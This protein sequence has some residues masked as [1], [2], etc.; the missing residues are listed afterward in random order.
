MTREDVEQYRSRFEA[1]NDWE[2]RQPPIECS[3]E[4]VIA[5][6]GFLL[7]F[8][9]AEERL[10]DPDPEKLGVQRMRAALAAASRSK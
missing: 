7:G 5:D 1:F 9:D 8:V 2:A 3:A 6:L 10:R 4:A